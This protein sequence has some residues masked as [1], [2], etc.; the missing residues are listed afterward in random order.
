MLQCQSLWE[1]ANDF[2]LFCLFLFCF[3]INQNLWSSISGGPRGYPSITH[4]F[5]TIWFWFMV[6]FASFLNNQIASVNS[7]YFRLPC[8]MKETTQRRDLICKSIT[9]FL[10]PYHAYVRR[11]V[12]QL[13]A[14]NN[15]SC[16]GMSLG[17]MKFI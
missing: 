9:L 5:L 2:G 14:R 12:C 10:Y 7:L 13:T 15:N 11:Q 3:S 16:A 4:Q 1:M 8:L 6:N 17:H